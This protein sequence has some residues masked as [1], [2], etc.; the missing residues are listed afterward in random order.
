M[1]KKTSKDEQVGFHKGALSTLFNERNELLRLINV[2]DAFIQAHVKALK[3]LGVDIEA[4]LAK[5]AKEA[6]KAAAKK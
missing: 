5:A 4:E 2:V 1:A 6:Q 3:E